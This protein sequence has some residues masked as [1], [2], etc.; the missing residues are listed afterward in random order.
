M[1][2]AVAGGANRPMTVGLLAL[3]DREFF[4][5]LLKNPRQAILDATKAGRLGEL[6]SEEIDLI[7]SLVNE[8]KQV[9][10]KETLEHWDRYQ[11]TGIWSPQDWPRMWHCEARRPTAP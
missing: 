6:T 5:H 7:T 3:R 2:E 1:G 4:A 9:P 11:I 10:D 8:R